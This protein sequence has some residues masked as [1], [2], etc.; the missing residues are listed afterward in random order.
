MALEDQESGFCSLERQGICIRFSEGP[1]QVQPRVPTPHKHDTA[2]TRMKSTASQIPV[3]G[4]SSINRKIIWS[5]LGQGLGSTGGCDGV[6]C[7]VVGQRRAGAV[8]SCWECPSW[9]AGGSRISIPRHRALSR[10]GVEEPAVPCPTSPGLG[11]GR[12]S[13][14]SLWD[15]TAVLRGNQGEGILGQGSENGSRM[16]RHL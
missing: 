1:S 5:V 2:E 14:L 7:I 16:G 8:D 4:H 10:A 15:F 12:D 11:K 9:D 3:N 13:G 6:S